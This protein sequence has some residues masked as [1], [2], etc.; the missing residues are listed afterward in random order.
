MLQLER[1]RNNQFDI[2][3]ILKKGGPEELK[4]VELEPT[5]QWRMLEGGE[6]SLGVAD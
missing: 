2:D 6:L 1:L 3:Q 4:L 5:V